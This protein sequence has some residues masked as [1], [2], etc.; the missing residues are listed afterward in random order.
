[1][2][3]GILADIVVL[4]HLFFVLFT[5]LGG[6]LVLWKHYLAWLHVPAALWAAYIEIAGGICPLT[7]LENWLRFQSG[8]STYAGSFIAHYMGSLLYPAELTRDAQIVM[9]LG[10]VFIN[11]SIYLWLLLRIKQSDGFGRHRY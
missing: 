2:I 6:F 11:V 9:G 1:M 8:D 3:Y 7:P 5:V 10:V 4:I